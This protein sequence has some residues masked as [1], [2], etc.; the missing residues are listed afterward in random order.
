MTRDKLAFVAFEP[1]NGQFVALLSM[2][3]LVSGQG[4]PELVLRKAAKVYER[5]TMTMKSVIAEIQACR[6][7]GKLVPARKIWRLGDAI[8]E[9]TS[10]LQELSLQIDRLYDH[11]VRDLGAKRKWLEKAIIFRRYLPDEALVPE[12]LN[13]GRCEKGTRKAA[14]RLR[15]GLPPG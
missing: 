7:D 6:A 15:D 10:Q 8:F 14:E 13:W 9:L 3:G 4:D 12:S 5:A 2:Q 1:T 11:L